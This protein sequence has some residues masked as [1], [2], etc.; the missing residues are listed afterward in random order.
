M[1]DKKMEKNKK[2]KMLT[3]NDKMITTNNR[4]VENVHWKYQG[5]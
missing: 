4:G 2:I 3:K 1:D 5:S